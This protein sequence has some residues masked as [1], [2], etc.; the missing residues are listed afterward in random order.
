MTEWDVFLNPVI[1]CFFALPGVLAPLREI[2]KQ[3]STPIGN[4]YLTCRWPENH[5]SLHLCRKYHLCV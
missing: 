5:I 2:Q 4:K 3:L 1:F